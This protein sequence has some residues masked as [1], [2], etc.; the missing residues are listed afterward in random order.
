MPTVVVLGVGVV[1]GVLSFGEET[2]AL[3]VIEPAVAG[4]VTTIVMGGAA[5]GARLPPVRLQVTVPER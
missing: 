1:A 3:F 5:P 2:V 4:A